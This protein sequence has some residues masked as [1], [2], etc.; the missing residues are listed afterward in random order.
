MVIDVFSK[1]GWIVPLK[2]CSELKVSILS[3]MW[4]PV[5]QGL[6]TPCIIFSMCSCVYVEFVVS[7][8]SCNLFCV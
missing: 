5:M 2:S 8:R 1:Y 6:G 7:R 4:A 3:D